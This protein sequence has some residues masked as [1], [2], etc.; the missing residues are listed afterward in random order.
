MVNWQKLITSDWG[1]SVD[2]PKKGQEFYNLRQF[3][4]RKKRRG[5]QPSVNFNKEKK[6]IGALKGLGG[7]DLEICTY[8][9]WKTP[10]YSPD[11]F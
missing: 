4:Y 7:R 11:P 10:G 5:L 2:E 3:I 9:A 8:P 6:K 1:S